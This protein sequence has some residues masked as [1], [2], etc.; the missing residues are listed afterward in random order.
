MAKAYLSVCRQSVRSFIRAHGIAV[1][2]VLGMFLPPAS[3]A[4]GD[5]LFQDDFERSNPGTVGNG[6][7]VTPPN[8]DAA[9]SGVPPSG[10]AYPTAT[11]TIGG[12]QLVPVTGVTVGGQQIMAQT[13]A[14]NTSPNTVAS[15][16]RD[17]INACTTSVTGNCTVAGYS[18]TRSNNV[19]TI[20]GP[21][22]ASGT[23]V[24]TRGTPS[25][26][27]TPETFTVTA[28]TAYNPGTYNASTNTGCAGIDADVPPWNST[29]L[30][31]APRAND[32]S[33]TL[34]TR[35]STVTVDSPVINLAGKPAAQITF[36]VRRGSDCF[37]E[38]PGNNQTKCNVALTPFTSLLGEEF[39]VQY[40]NNA[41]NWLVLAQYPTDAIPGEIFRPV[42]DLPPDALHATFQMRF[43]QPGGSGS[44]GG[45][46]GAPGVLGYDYWHVDDVRVTELAAT[47]YAGGFCDTFEGDLSRWTFIGT[48]NAAIGATHFQNGA[49]G[50]DIRWGPVAVTS[51]ATD[52][53]T[54]TDNITFWVKRGIGNFTKVP[55]T[56]GS[57]QP[58]T[59]K[60]L[61]VEYLTTTPGV[62]KSLV[63]AATF[64]GGGTGGQIW[65]PVTGPNCPAGS[66]S[67]STN[68]PIPADANRSAFQIRFRSISGAGYD[69]DYW[70]LD[71]ICVG[72]VVTGTDLS[73]AMTP[74]G[75]T[76]LPPGA[77]STITFT[78]TNN[79]P[80][81]EPGAI[82]VIDTLPTG[83]SFVSNGAWS[84]GGWPVGLTGCTTVGQVLTCTR[85]GSLAVGASVTL[86]VTVQADATASGSNLANVATVGG[87]SLETAAAN[88]TATNYYTFTPAVFEAYETSTTPTTAIVGRI[89]TKLAGT[90]FNLKVI[91][92]SG[93]AINPNYNKAVT[94]DLIDGTAACISGTAALAGVTVTPNPYTYST[95]TDKG[96][97]TFSF[98]STNAYRNVRV[99]IRDNNALGCSSD[100]FAIRPSAA[101][102]V[103]T[104]TAVAPSA[105]ATPTVKAGAIFSLQAT[106]NASS[107]Y[108]GTLTLDPGKLSAQSTSQDTSVQS[109]GVVGALTPSAL[110]ANAGA[111]N[112]T[113][114]EVG[115]LYLAAGSYRD[116]DFTSIDSAAGD[117]VTSTVG[118]AYLADL[119]DANG[120]YGC[121]IGNKSLV[122]LGRFIPDHFD[123][124][125]VQSGLSPAVVPM[126][127]PSVLTCPA[128]VSG[129]TGMVYSGQPFS[130]QVSA[131]NLSNAL[132]SNYQGVFAKTTILG[133]VNAPGGGGTNPGGGTLSNGTLGSA[134]FAAGVATTPTPSYALP[135]SG[136]TPTVGP[137]DVFLRA[138]DADGASSST[139]ESGL[140]VA[141]GRILIPNAYGSERLALPVAATVQYYNASRWV[142]STTDSSTTF[143]TTLSTSGG[144]LA[145]T[146]KTGLGSGINVTSPGV[147][148]VSSGQ[149]S[150]VLNSVNQTQG[151]VWLSLNAPT[152]LPSNQGLATFGVYK[153]P[154]IYHREN[155]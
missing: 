41:G 131:K 135:T 77:T 39:Q 59:G 58:E 142:T 93:G 38:W 121:S 114:S 70:H 116:D 95:G 51:K 31:L 36:W 30:P 25:G 101:T 49:H 149:R 103:T 111:V 128:N 78:I 97:H 105:T 73:L 96:V 87:Q 74:L 100:N 119:L 138:T 19:V 62:W 23:P 55:N 4:P 76:T 141:S 120:K 112:A 91:S 26:G 108:S 145:A 60:D 45:N 132:T 10:A 85:A 13:Y 22:T 123:T 102:L 71:D 155:Y 148:S 99:R 84:S 98:N 63:P 144:N 106:T 3:A 24:V 143:D 104:A 2:M 86:T 92:V 125:I 140:K 88:N 136:G 9:C 124:V 147:A 8:T 32:N 81:V 28:F 113:Y 11:I 21:S 7:T 53:S 1:W 82:S 37:S 133:A 48:G 127:C 146:V 14:G 139:N 47:N 20:T 107:S 75:T 54:V 109:G 15:N 18:A 115:Y 89:F 118:D 126:A 83:L 151:S 65:C 129:A 61:L 79:G 34:F 12:S 122:S 57:D 29:T 90:A 110:V 56:S 153:S 137:T 43:R 117:C 40:K 44:G 150:I 5:I 130:V 33:R 46:G 6:W 50:L 152:Y 66:V 69:Q 52:I 16:I 94:V 27:G 134:A 72:K 154:L 35:W 80:N 64:G 17:Q 42:I 68:V 67:A